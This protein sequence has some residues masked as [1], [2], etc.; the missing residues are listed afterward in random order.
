LEMAGDEDVAGFSV[1]ACVSVFPF[2]VLGGL[3]S[4]GKIDAKALPRD[5]SF[6]RRIVAT[7]LLAEFGGDA[8]WTEVENGVLMREFGDPIN[9]VVGVIDVFIAGMA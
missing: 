7:R 3:S 1:D 9:V 5:C 4:E 2:G 6:T 8:S